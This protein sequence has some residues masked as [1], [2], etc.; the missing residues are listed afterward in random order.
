MKF[1]IVCF[2]GDNMEL[3]AAKIPDL[4]HA[5]HMASHMASWFFTRSEKVPG[6]SVYTDERGTI[7]LH[8]AYMS[9]AR[10]ENHA[11]ETKQSKI[12]LAEKLRKRTDAAASAKVFTIWMR[13]VEFWNSNVSFLDLMQD[14]VFKAAWIREDY[15]AMND[16]MI[17][18][19]FVI[20]TVEPER[21]AA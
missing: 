20:P 11:S 2:R 9:C 15:N 12:T 1:K 8:L 17:A 21:I 19:G 3:L 18:L 13:G 5:C 7:G 14:A 6:V 4:D 16:R 10:P